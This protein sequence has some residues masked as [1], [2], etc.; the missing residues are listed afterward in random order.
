[1]IIL[2]KNIIFLEAKK[3]GHYSLILKPSKFTHIHEDCSHLAIISN[4]NSFARDQ[5][6]EIAVCAATP[7]DLITWPVV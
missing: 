6:V 7:K 3:A 5:M 4:A 2:K 1:M